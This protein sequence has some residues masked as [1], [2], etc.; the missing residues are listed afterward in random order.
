MQTSDGPGSAV[1]GPAV[2]AFFSWMQAR[3]ALER[4]LLSWVRTAASLIGFGFAIVH[5]FA[6]IEA[7][8]EIAPAWKPGAARVLGT[9]LAIVGTVAL[10]LATIQYVLLVRYFEGN[11][12]REISRFAGLPRFRPALTVTIA[13]LAVGLIVCWALLARVPR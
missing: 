5:F 1:S 11:R 4:T 10:A 9:S 6:A 8:P 13:L 3:M 2:A 12:F 7:A